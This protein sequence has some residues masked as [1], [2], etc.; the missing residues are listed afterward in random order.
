[1]LLIQ[2]NYFEIIWDVRMAES[3]IHNT[4]KIVSLSTSVVFVSNV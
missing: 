4:D 3:R 2:C 1:M